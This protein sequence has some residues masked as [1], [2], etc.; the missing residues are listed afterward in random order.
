MLALAELDSSDWDGAYRNLMLAGQTMRD[1]TSL[2][3]PEPLIALGVMET[4]RRHPSEAAGVFLEALKYAPQN[5]LALQELGRSQVL[6]QNWEAAEQS[7]SKAL[8][9][10]AGPRRASC[11]P[12]PYWGEII[13]KPRAQP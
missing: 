4:W 12:R 6:T 11:W 8:A 5:P 13:P 1:D 3:R 10:G 2:G 7:F 9:A